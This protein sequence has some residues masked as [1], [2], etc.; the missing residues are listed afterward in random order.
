M[1]FHGLIVHFFLVLNNI[2]LSGC[3]T[4]F[5]TFTH[6]RNI[7]VAF[8]VWGVINKAAINIHEQ[9]FVWTYVFQLLWVNTK[10]CDYWI[11]W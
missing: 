3:D 8:Q 10:E 2:P 7:S 4:V 6:G 1:S 11:I 5:N 9:V